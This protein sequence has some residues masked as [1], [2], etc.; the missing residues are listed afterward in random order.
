MVGFF[1]NSISTIDKFPFFGIVRM[2][3]F[4]YNKK[5]QNSYCLRISV[6]TSYYLSTILQLNLIISWKYILKIYLYGFILPRF[7]S[8][9][10]FH[11]WCH[12]KIKKPRLKKYEYEFWLSHVNIIVV[13]YPELI[14]FTVSNVLYYFKTKAWKDFRF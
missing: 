5:F 1:F 9:V 4:F 11:F 10:L 14:G 13:I 2:I 6:W 8:I 7:S 3:Q 12:V